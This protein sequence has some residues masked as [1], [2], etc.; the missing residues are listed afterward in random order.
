MLLRPLRLL[1]LVGCLSV[2]SLAASEIGEAA[3]DLERQLD[4]RPNNGTQG[5]ARDVADQLLRLG[6]RERD[7]GNFEAAIAA[8]YRAIDIYH[9]LGDMPSAGIAYDYIGLTYAELGRYTEAEGT[10]R[11]RL[12]IAQDSE[13]YRG[14]VFGW[15][16]L[17]S[18][19]I[20]RGQLSTARDAFQNALTVAEDVRDNAGI[21]LSLSN[22]GLVAQIRG[23]LQDARKYYE[24]AADYRFRAGDRSGEANT[25]NNLGQVY[26]E[27]G[28]DDRAIGAFRVARDAAQQADATASLL[29][30]LDGLIDIYSDRGDLRQVQRFLD[31][32]LAVTENAA[33]SPAQ[34]LGALIQ[35][36]EYYEQ[37]DALR[38]A[39][40][41]Y[42]QALAIAQA[43]DDTSREA[44]LLNRLQGL[45]RQLG[46]LPSED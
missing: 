6:S 36:A 28:L 27:L 30:A 44:M 14:Q 8:W 10:L 33:A 26:R 5:E 16:N 15:N 38:Q 35:L 19:F 9:A 41:T 2:G 18:V 40:E 11:R 22:L 17:G 20:Q 29:R 42:G 39:I 21:G 34:R 3:E 1:L 43:I 12:A 13:D 23:H 25:S 46:A 7:R 32:R 24:T 45:R 31:E 37:T 4:I